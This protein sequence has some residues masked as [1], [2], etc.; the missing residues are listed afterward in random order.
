MVALHLGTKH[1]H[2]GKEMQKPTCLALGQALA[3]GDLEPGLKLP[4]VQPGSSSKWHVTAV[5]APD[6]RRA[7]GPGPLLGR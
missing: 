1:P 7:A 4:F 2:S 6:L 5:S 3:G